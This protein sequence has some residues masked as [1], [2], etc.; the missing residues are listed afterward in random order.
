MAEMT[1]EVEAGMVGLTVPSKVC[2]WRS[3]IH[4]LRFEHTHRH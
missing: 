4:V 1:V 2:R 3:L